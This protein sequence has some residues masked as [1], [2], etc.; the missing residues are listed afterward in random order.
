MKEIR[1]K[2]EGSKIKTFVQKGYVSQE[3]EKIKWFSEQ[4]QY[5]AY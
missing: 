2:A 5:P 3:G 4:N 1:T